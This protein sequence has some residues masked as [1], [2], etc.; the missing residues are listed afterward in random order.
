MA[1]ETTNSAGYVSMGNV[2]INP[3]G[4]YDDNTTYYFLDMVSFK[5]GSYIC[6]KD[7]TIGVRPTLNTT[8]DEW[9]CSSIPGSATEEFNTL[10]AQVQA[11][12]QAAGEAATNAGKSA[13]AAS[14]SATAAE[15]SATDAEN[16]AKDAEDAKDVVAG[17]KRATESAKDSAEQSEQN[18]ESMIKGLDQ[19]FA[20]K[21][22]SAIEEINTA[23][24][25]KA[26]E[27]NAEIEQTKATIVEEAQE[28]VDEVIDARKAEIN[29]TGTEQINAVKSQG[30][31]Q[32]E[33]VNDTA[34]DQI[35]A[36]NAAGGTLESAIE[37]Y[38]AMRRGR[39]IY[40]VEELDADV[41]QSCAVNRLDGLEGLTCTPSTNETAGV[42][43]IGTLEAFR[44]LN[45][46]WILDENGNQK[47]TAIEGMPGYKKTGKINRGVMNMGL[48][49][50]KERN[51]ED[52]GWLHHWSMLPREEEGY[53]PMSECVR[54][55]GTVQGWMIHP[56][57]LAVEIEGTPYVTNG[58][59]VRKKASFANYAYARKQG[60]AYCFETDADACWIQAL[61][62]IKYGTKSIQEVMKGCT[63]YYY[64]YKVAVAEANVKR[65][66]LTTAQANTLVVG[67]C[68]SIGDP[69]E[70]ESLDRNYDY[71][72]NVADSAM[73]TAI[74]ALDDTNSAVYLDVENPITTT[75]DCYVSTMF[76]RTGSTDAVKG[77]DG[78]PVSNTDSKCICKINEIE[79][80]QGGWVVSGNSL[81]I[82]ET[83]AEGNTTCT[84]YK[85]NDSRD[86]TTNLDTI[87]SSYEKVG[88]FPQTN[89]SWQYIKDQSVDF[90]KGIMLPVEWGGGSSTYWGD[91]WHT[92]TV[93]AAGQKSGR[94]LLRRGNLSGGSICGASC[95]PGYD[96]L[97]NAYW[98]ILATLS[99]NAIRGE[100]AA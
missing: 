9:F 73:I 100:W 18:V 88:T 81:H 35:A 45:V 95:V 71:M 17:Y 20:T 41:T 27:I 53:R 34:A 23:A 6:L 87:I 79:I 8:S 55:D 52:N 4:A 43:Q 19:T 80:L 68:I 84:Y 78:S 59:P 28:A 49:Y 30:E 33:N 37:R 40:T 5:G 69:G 66:I 21:T 51:A 3:R 62:M 44:P 85:N 48:Y 10:V 56:K 63:S 15:K 26:Q 32:V 46:N 86:L 64:Q 39:D 90:G 7:K 72:H 36:L 57:G 76:W 11:A 83:D 22:Q 82:I 42:D 67:S 99:P 60:S 89:N 92:G 65:V 47:I 94:E 98:Y 13:S 38:Y 74:E 91:A 54:P 1:N 14:E 97:G 31:L 50:K 29:A 75:T 24:D 58:N 61:T 16:A 2:T 77:Y 70:N 25:S 96:A 12:E 93:P